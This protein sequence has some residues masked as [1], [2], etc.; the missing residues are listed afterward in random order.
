MQ[1]PKQEKIE[2]KIY[3]KSLRLDFSIPFDEHSP[4]F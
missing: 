1:K 4:V 2:K 3:E